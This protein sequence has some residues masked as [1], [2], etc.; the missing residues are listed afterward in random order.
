MRIAFVVIQRFRNGT[1][2][3][4]SRNLGNLKWGAADGNSTESGRFEGAGP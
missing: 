4:Y 1:Q 2:S 3:G